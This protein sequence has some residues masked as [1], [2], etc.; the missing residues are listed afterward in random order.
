MVCNFYLLLFTVF[1][2]VNCQ[3]DLQDYG[4]II[5]SK[6]KS[7]F[8]WGT[9]KPN[10]YFSMKNRRNTSDV[11]GIMWYGSESSDFQEQGSLSKRLRH[12]CRMEDGLNYRWE[13]HNGIDFGSQVIEDEVNLLSLNTKFIKHSYNETQSWSVYIKGKKSNNKKT[14]I[15][16]YTSMENF[17][18]A[19][20]SFFNTTNLHISKD[21]ADK[22]C[23]SAM[24]RGKQKYN[25]EISFGD[26]TNLVSKS[27]QKYRKRYNETWRVK[28]FVLEDLEPLENSLNKKN[29]TYEYQTFTTNNK[30]ESPNILV[31]QLI[32]DKDFDIIVKFSEKETTSNN[33]NF[34]EFLD[35]ISQKES[36]FIKKFDQIYWN[37]LSHENFNKLAINNEQ[38]KLLL[39][40]MS[41]QALS[42]ILGGIGYFW[43]AI[44]INLDGKLEEGKYHKGFRYAVENKGL[45]TGTPSRSYFARGFLWDEGFHNI[46]ISQW[47]VNMSVDILDSWL[48][49]MSA[50]GWIAREQIRGGEAESQV[51]QKFIIQDKQV[52]NPP[53]FI[54]ALENILSFYKYHNDELNLKTMKN[55]LKKC[56]DKFGAWYEW[57]ENYQKSPD[58]KSY[59]WF[60]RNSEHNLASGLDD[61]PR[62]MSPNIYERH[63]DLTIWVAELI[64]TLRNI[65]ELFDYELVTHFDKQYRKIISDLPS[66]FYDDKKAVYNDYLGPQFKLVKT[67]NYKREVPPYLWRGDGRCGLEAPNP[68]GQASECNPYSDAPCCSEFGWCG[69]TQNHCKCPKCSKAEKLEN[70]PDFQERQNIFNPHL[71]YINLYPI[72]FG[73]IKT[74]DPAFRGT[75]NLLKSDDELFS[76]YGIRSLSKSDMLYHTGEDYWR[77]NIWMNLNFLTLRGLYKFY[78][79]NEEAMQVYKKIRDN[80]IK[81]VFSQWK[82]KK[83]FYEQ[84]S[85]R[86][87]QGLKARPFNGWTSLILNIITEKY[88]A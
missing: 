82:S 23:F 62:G 28:K 15:F 2:L 78:K 72:F 88:D 56:F 43:G 39:K 45:F 8:L 65:S 40:E 63:L 37:R 18:V 51:P 57:Y 16:L 1:F 4:V 73:L 38:E 20:K 47:D 60:G 32:F 6:H 11:F 58:R 36:E 48:S 42:N 50:T 77:G 79:Q 5:D 54:F 64:K 84:Y 76:E 80:L 22:F 86:D 13:M 46:I 83:T 10:L 7:K 44:K 41:Q 33:N 74:E 26:S 24:E 19:D 34:V 67:S 71:G 66:Q 61:Y 81:N 87:G 30:I 14:S 21:S 70:R 3:F 27:F 17:E 69:N 52:A 55:F 31:I 53:T 68:L 85:D 35:H 59:Q 9:Y 25:Y 12:N 75:M 29:E 49:T